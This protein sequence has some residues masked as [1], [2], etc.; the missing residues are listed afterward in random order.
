VPAA[1]NVWVAEAPELDAEPSP[2][3]MLLTLAVVQIPN[4]LALTEMG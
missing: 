3:L 4:A 1:V 2:K